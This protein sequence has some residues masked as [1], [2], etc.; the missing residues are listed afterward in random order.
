MQIIERLIQDSAVTTNKI[1]NSAVNGD[2]IAANAVGATHIADDAVGSSEIAD[3]AI[4]AAH[5]SEA[6][7]KAVLA[8]KIEKFFDQSAEIGVEN[9][10]SKVV[11]DEFFTVAS[12]KKTDGAYN[13][14]G[15]VTSVPH[16][17]CQIR[18]FET[19]DP[20]EDPSNR[21]V[22]G[23]L[24]RA[25]TALTGTVSFTG[26]NVAV[27]GTDTLFTSE[28]TAGDYIKLNSAGIC[29]KVASIESDTALTLASV[30]SGATGS[31]ASSKVVL[32]L[33][34]YV[35]ADNTETAHTIF[36][37]GGSKDIEIL[38]PEAIDLD[39][40]PFGA[41]A[42]SV[43]F[44][45]SL[46]ASHLHDDRYYTETEIGQ[47]SGTPGAELV[48]YDNTVSGYEATDVQAAID[49]V[50]VA[51]GEAGGDPEVWFTEK[52]SITNQD[53]IPNLSQTP[54]GTQLVTM[55]VNGLAQL[56]DYDFF[57]SG[58]A[59]TWS[60]TNAGFHL[61]AGDVVIVGYNTVIE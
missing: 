7:K 54:S 43:A 17:K 25:N 1:A 56:E 32:T 46:P 47:T 35:M 61:E 48:G 40:L 41:M 24:T 18:D 14:V 59:M 29:A 26:S 51:V 44:S 36:P 28:L 12:Y 60:H 21:Q 30:Y 2:K 39:S 27:T 10:A 33:S 53:T 55:T 20:V 42:N 38:Y 49:E 8:S 31:G 50:I 9:Q 23:R 22:Y 52:L 37:T 16:N 6:S 45:E 13:A 57:Q 15:L 4:L 3:A 5:L 19:G 11:T 34:F 58:K